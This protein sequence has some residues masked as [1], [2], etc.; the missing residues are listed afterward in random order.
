MQ[1]ILS[2]RQTHEQKALA[3]KVQHD[4][5]MGD[6]LRQFYE[7]CARKYVTNISPC[8]IITADT[9]RCKNSLNNDT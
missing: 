8:L 1:L 7:F 2:L 5:P 6:I 3:N 9:A 4:A